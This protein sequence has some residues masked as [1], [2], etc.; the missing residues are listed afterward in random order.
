MVRMVRKLLRCFL[1]CSLGAVSASGTNKQ[2]D[3]VISVVVELS[4]DQIGL[5]EQATLQVTVS[6]QTQNLPEPDVPELPAFEVYSQG[7]SSNISVVNGQMSATVTYRYL[8]VPTK[9][10]SFPIERIGVV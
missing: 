5:D 6:G 7:R 1:V 2:S 8:L 9:A 3:D 10:G 4:R